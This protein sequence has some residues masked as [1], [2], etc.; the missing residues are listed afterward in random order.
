[1][2]ERGHRKQLHPRSQSFGVLREKNKIL[3]K[4]M[5]TN[6]KNR[7][8]DWK[9]TPIKREAWLILLIY[10]EV[11]V[12]EF[13]QIEGGMRT[14][15]DAFTLY[16]PRVIFFTAIFIGISLL[17]GDRPH[18]QWGHQSVKTKNQQRSKS[19]KSAKKKTR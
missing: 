6:T 1:M 17:I 5:N 11:L 8:A 3:L 9:W 12:Y 7:T 16:A 19:R 4:K 10:V 15:S 18:W 2:Q 14:A 13:L